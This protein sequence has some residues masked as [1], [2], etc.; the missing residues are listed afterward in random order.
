MLRWLERK[1]QN[2]AVEST[3]KDLDRFVAS[4]R[5][6][7]DETIGMIVAYAAVLREVLTQQGTLPE[8]ILDVD[9]FPMTEEAGEVPTR[10][11]K[12][13]EEFQKD[14]QEHTAA[15]IMVWL[16]SVRAMVYPEATYLGQQMWAELRRGFPYAKDALSQLPATV[17]TNVPDEAWSS[18]KYVPPMLAK[19]Y[20]I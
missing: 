3:Q 12:L 14:N 11:R 10:L 17:G 4:L 7:P 1:I 19:R 20:S 6:Q 18:Y 5:G 16:H 2:K 15:A 9:V 13:V 8:G